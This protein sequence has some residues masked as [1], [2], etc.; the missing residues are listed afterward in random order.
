MGSNGSSA[1]RPLPA[2]TGLATVFDSL[3]ERVAPD[4]APLGYERIVGHAEGARR[5]TGAIGGP[6][7]A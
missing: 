5:T 2:C 7:M 6:S 4:R 3:R 1:A